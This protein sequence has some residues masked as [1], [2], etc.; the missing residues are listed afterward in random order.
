MNSKA[1]ILLCTMAVAL[2]A[3]ASKKPSRQDRHFNPERIERLYTDF[4]SRWDYNQDG[5]ATCDD[6]LVKRSRLFKRLDE[7]QD[8]VL[9]SREYRHARFED[10]S[11]MFF[12]MDRI[13]SNGSTT[14]EI[15]EFIDVPHSQFINMDKDGNCTLNKREALI[16][17][18]DRNPDIAQEKRGK[19]KRGINRKLHMASH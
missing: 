18:R 17:M 9:T 2:S 19:G 15:K 4:I 11:F 13:D 16:A 5:L 8:G 10:K 3:C 14:V 7:D 1:L 12:E 6:I